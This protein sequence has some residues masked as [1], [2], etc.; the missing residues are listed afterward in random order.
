MERCFRSVLSVSV[1]ISKG[2]GTGLRRLRDGWDNSGRAEDKARRLTI[3]RPKALAALAD[4][5]ASSVY[6][7]YQGL[8]R[9]SATTLTFVFTVYVVVLL[10]TM[11]CLAR[12]LITRAVG[13]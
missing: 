5:I 8:F 12:S 6:R 3:W 2:A 11:I 10:V 9:F 1:R 13:G 7:V 4:V